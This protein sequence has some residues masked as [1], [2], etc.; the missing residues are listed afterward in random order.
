M[1]LVIC[2]N[3]ETD[4]DIASRESS[5]YKPYNFRNALSSNIMLP[6]DCQV[7][8]QS[9]KFN[10]DGS[11][12]IG[13]NNRVF[14]QYFGPYL[15]NA[16]FAGISTSN[17]TPVRVTFFDNQS[18]TQRVTAEQL[19]AEITRATN[20]RLY[21]PNLV[22][23][24]TCST[25][26]DTNNVFKGYKFQ[27]D[28]ED[29]RILQV[30]PNLTD[31]NAFFSKVNDGSRPKNYSYGAG[32]L[33]TTSHNVAAGK[34]DKTAQITF[35]NTPPINLYGGTLK[36]D[37]TGCV[38]TAGGN[39]SATIFMCGLTRSANG[40]GFSHAGFGGT[41][42]NPPNYIRTRNNS[43]TQKAFERMIDY[44]IYVDQNGLLQVQHSPVLSANDSR[45]TQDG[46]IAREFPTKTFLQYWNAS[47]LGSDF[48]GAGPYD[49]DTNASDIDS[50]VFSVDGEQVKISLLDGATT[51]TLVEYNATKAKAFNLK[52][53]TQ[54][55]WDMLP[56]LAI[57]NLDTSINHELQITEYTP[58]SWWLGY[59]FTNR[60]TCGWQQR[61]AYDGRLMDIVKLEE[62]TLNDYSIGAGVA[63]PF[64]YSKVAVGNP[65][66]FEN[67][68][69]V[70]TLL[71]DDLYKPSVGANV[72]KLFGFPNITSLGTA[73]FWQSTHNT[74]L[75][76]FAISVEVPQLLANRSIFV[77]LDNMTQESYN[78]KQGNRSG[79]IAHIPKFQGQAETRRIFHEPN[80][81]VYLD[82][83]NPE[84]IR[85]NSFD[86]SFVYSNE[87]YVDSMVGS[88]IVVLHFKSKQ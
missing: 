9:C 27:Y 73:G 31:T 33:S 72:D 75:D 46:A 53:I 40:P 59:D 14:Y 12:T 51:Y 63:N 13:K 41:L 4:A 29:T 42:I 2:S 23:Q 39:A 54:A 66:I 3:L 34:F 76:E 10:L 50:V 17:A 58:A 22:N 28:I 37:I 19:A 7:A 62:R 20:S 86:I 82:L 43:N 71:Q 70:L 6:K 48:I 38:N 21:H 35:K 68:H 16:S 60:Q 67:R 5:I 49:F 30:P 52:P 65:Q 11:I 64:T 87:Q 1:S 79:I 88:S 69:P 8:L 47:N 15:N 77:R 84:P 56:F 18:D 45:V 57:A 55:C 26:L 81:L 25:V 83:N 78:A 85:I 24:F 74:S 32:T 80:T 44:G 36:I 61:L